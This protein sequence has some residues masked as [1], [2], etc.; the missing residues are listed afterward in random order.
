MRNLNEIKF[1]VLVLSSPKSHPNTLF[2]TIFVLFCFAISNLELQACMCVC[3]FC[4]CLLKFV[5]FFYPLNCCHFCLNARARIHNRYSYHTMCVC[6][7]RK[8]RRN[9][10]I[11]DH[12]HHTVHFANV[13]S[14]H[15]TILLLL[16]EKKK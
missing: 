8:K 3:V 16:P 15:C 9:T 7:L 5:N 2:A 10:K 12:T 4:I 11:F 6:V 1:S 13:C 14:R